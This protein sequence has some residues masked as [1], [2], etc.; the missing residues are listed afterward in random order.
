[1]PRLSLTATLS[2]A[3]ALITLL[4]FYFAGSY[5]YDNLLTQLLRNETTEILLKAQHL[6]SLAAEE[7]SAAALR[8]DASR[9]ASQ[10]AGNDA[11]VVQ[12]RSSDSQMLLDFNPSGLPV[13]ALA[14]I[15]EGAPA[16]DSDLQQWRTESGATVRGVA[17][18]TRLRNGEVVTLILGRSL[19]DVMS[20][21][22]SYR[23]TVIRTVGLGALAAM[24]L[25]YALVRR[26]CDRCTG[27]R[28][29]RAGSPSMVLTRVLTRP[30]RRRNCAS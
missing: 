4:T 3:F 11:F 6:R 14:A 26:R 1:M 5:L 16:R 30:I 8:A 21:L 23:R 27:S 19:D 12:F 17:A 24:V 7:D 25:S 10:I 9:I 22:R 15:P 28:T 18:Q 29:R 2:G 13:V 20:L